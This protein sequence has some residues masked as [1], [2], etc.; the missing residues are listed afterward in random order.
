MTDWDDIYPPV[1]VDPVLLDVAVLRVKDII[2]I[3]PQPLGPGP[4]SW[5]H[6]FHKFEM[7]CDAL[8]ITLR[9]LNVVVWEM[10]PRLRDTDGCVNF[11]YSA[12]EIDTPSAHFRILKCVRGA[13]NT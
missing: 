6:K 2:N 5:H 11:L 4:R 9:I 3:G 7:F 10:R 8:G 1:S 12:V 13:E